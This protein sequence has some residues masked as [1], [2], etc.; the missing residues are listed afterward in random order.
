MSFY[1]LSPMD[2]WKCSCTD[3]LFNIFISLLAAIIATILYGLSPLL[4]LPIVF[5]IFAKR[6]KSRMLEYPYTHKA[7]GCMVRGN[8]VFDNYVKSL[9]KNNDNLWCDELYL[10]CLYYT[11]YHLTDDHLSSEKDRNIY[12]RALV[13]IIKISSAKNTDNDETKRALQGIYSEYFVNLFYDHWYSAASISGLNGYAKQYVRMLVYILCV[14]LTLFWSFTGILIYPRLNT[15]DG[16]ILSVTWGLRD[17]FHLI[18]FMVIVKL[19]FLQIK[20]EIK[21][22]FCW[23][24][25]NCHN[26]YYSIKSKKRSFEL[27]HEILWFNITGDIIHDS[28]IKLNDTENERI[29]WMQKLVMEYCTGYGHKSMVY[30]QNDNDIDLLYQ[31]VHDQDRY[32]CEDKEWIQ[33]Q[34][35]KNGNHKFDDVGPFP[36]LI[37]L[38][39]E[40]VQA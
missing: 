2:H 35:H 37:K 26:C 25:P 28:L 18:L 34:I 24:N 39:I 8:Q 1:G 32:Q 40:Q 30:Y 10:R 4:C 5:I 23:R 33:S 7:F 19:Y 15:D 22:R 12:I 20:S 9:I 17:L 38:L 21:Y 36:L 3:L 6:A 29:E 11:A 27:M 14:E 13:D 16:L 31:M